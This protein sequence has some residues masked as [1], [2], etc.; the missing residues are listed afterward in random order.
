M[1]DGLG[2]KRGEENKAQ[3]SLLLHQYRALSVSSLRDPSPLRAVS[4]LLCQVLGQR[5][6]TTRSLLHGNM[7]KFVSSPYLSCVTRAHTHTKNSKPTALQDLPIS[8]LTQHPSST[9]V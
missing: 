2:H 6:F 5:I 3:L 4:Q 7:S 1:Q 8:L 9:S